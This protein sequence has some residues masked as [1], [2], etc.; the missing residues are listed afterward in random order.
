MSD[1]FTPNFGNLLRPKRH[2]CFRPEAELSPKEDFGGSGD[3]SV[4]TAVINKPLVLVGMPEKMVRNSY[5]FAETVFG[6]TENT[7]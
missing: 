6:Y 5:A 4:A 1:R 7:I 3:A 2:G